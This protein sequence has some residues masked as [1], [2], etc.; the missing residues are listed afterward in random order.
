MSRIITLLPEH[1]E[2]I[3]QAIHSGAYQ[4]PEQ[5]IGRALETLRSEDE[6]L[7]E[8]KHSIHEKIERAFGQIER[9]ECF[10]AEESRDDLE[11][12]KAA[13]LADQKR[14]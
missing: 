14:G 3:E 7:R 2:L 13:W 6:W 12:R 4:N 1:E 10:T 9:G 8:N 11:K 5:V